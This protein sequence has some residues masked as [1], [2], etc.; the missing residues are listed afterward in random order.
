MMQWLQ[1]NCISYD[2]MTTGQKLE[3]KD[4]ADN[5]VDDDDGNNNDDDDNDNDW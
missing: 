3:W 1:R 2:A 4:S 5:N